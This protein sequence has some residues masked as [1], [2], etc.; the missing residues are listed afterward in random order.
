M[1]VEFIS[2]TP[3]DHRLGRQSAKAILNRNNVLRRHKQ[4]AL[5]SRIDEKCG[6]TEFS[7]LFVKP[8]W[9]KKKDGKLRP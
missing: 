5:V 9:I 7:I 8:N 6:C 1:F 4:R 2:V 3:I